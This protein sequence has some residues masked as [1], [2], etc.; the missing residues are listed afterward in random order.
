MFHRIFDGFN[1]KQD[2]IGLQHSWVL[3][4]LLIY[5]YFFRKQIM[6]SVFTVLLLLPLLSLAQQDSCGL[7]KSTDP[8]THETRISTGFVSFKT[9]ADNLYIS[10]DATAKD[11][12]IFLWLKDESKCFD[13][14]STV[15]LNYDGERMKA[16]FRNGGSMNCDGAFHIN[17]RNSATT[18]GNLQRIADKKIK[19]FR[20]TGNNNA[21][22]DIVLS[23]EQKVILMKMVS[24]VINQAKTLIK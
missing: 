22:T 24:C 14:Q 4:S 6:K 10:V 2:D 17:F 18:Q 21:V 13:E 3:K 19:S 16:N 15:Q 12:D 11:I 8:F 5:K 7:K 23:E 9:K 20:L 1:R